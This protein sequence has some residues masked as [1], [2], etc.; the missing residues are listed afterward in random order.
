L[1]QLRPLGPISAFKSNQLRSLPLSGSIKFVS[2]QIRKGANP[3]NRLG[4]HHMNWPKTKLFNMEHN[5][6]FP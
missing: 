6:L 3:V 5:Y 4:A 2:Q 1:T